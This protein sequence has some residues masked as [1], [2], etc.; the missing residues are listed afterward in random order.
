MRYYKL[1][2]LV[3]VGMII[4]EV[5]QNIVA[6]YQFERQY[7]YSWNLAD[8]SS[9]IEAK[10]EYIGLF[11]A[12]LNSNSTDFAENNV[13]WMTT[14][15][16]SFKMNL[17]ALQTL[18][19]R[20]QEIMKMDVKSFE[21]QT[22]IQQITQQEQGE[23]SKLINTIYGCW[24]KNKHPVVWEWFEFVWISI[25]ISLISVGSVMWLINYEI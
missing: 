18:N 11:V 1:M 12:M 10:A 25:W 22:A 23:A 4:Y 3:A 15:D 6:S 8:K 2:L 7:G 19:S 24:V 5:Q 16:N 17:M 13:Q 21:Y 20:L 14:P 9:T